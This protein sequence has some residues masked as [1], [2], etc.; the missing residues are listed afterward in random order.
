MRSQRRATATAVGGLVGMV[1]GIVGPLL[2]GLLI[3]RLGLIRGVRVSLFVTVL[4]TLAAVWVQRH[5]YRLRRPARDNDAGESV[6]A[7]RDAPSGLKNL[8]AAD[9]LLR[10]GSE[11]S[12]MF[13]ILYVVN[14][15]GSSELHFGFLMSVATL[16]AVLLTLP[17]AKL[18]DR[19]APRSRR[20]I[21]AAT[22]LLFAAFPLVLVVIPSAGWL[23]PVFVISGLRHVGEPVRKA[24]IIDL[25]EGPGRGRLIGV[26]HTIRGACVLPS[27]LIGGCLWEWSPAAP[28]LVGSGISVSGLIWFLL[29]RPGPGARTGT[30]LPVGEMS[31]DAG[32]APDNG[33]SPALAAG[34][35]PV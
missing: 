1:P 29:S 10:F 5:Y 33:R 2:G 24:L 22:Y 8:L 31:G 27:A 6:S 35:A 34:P 15:L 11:M 3:V 32:R 23:I 21:V 7:W 28:F 13:V 20:P 4:L 25:A 17:A 19:A 14:V 18:S 9:C 30:R 26:Y 12:A 16:T